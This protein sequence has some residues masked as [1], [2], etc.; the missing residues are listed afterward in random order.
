MCGLVSPQMRHGVKLLG[1]NADW[2]HTPIHIEVSRASKSA[3]DAIERAGGSV[4]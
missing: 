1:R 4:T 3:I 2:V